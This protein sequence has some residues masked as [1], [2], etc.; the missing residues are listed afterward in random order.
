M[1]LLGL[2]NPRGDMFA[3]TASFG[4]QAVIRL[5]SSLILTRILRPEDYGI[6][7]M[8]MAVVFVVQMIADLATQNV[9]IRHERGEEPDFL[10]TAW[11]LQFCRSLVNAAA[12]FLLAGPISRIYA[13][14]ALEAPLRLFS[15]WFVITGSQSMSFA[16]A[17]REKRARIFVYSELIA[18][19]LSTVFSIVI[20][21]YSRN[22]WGMVY[23]ILLNQLVL[24]ALSHHFYRHAR[25]RFRIERSAFRELMNYS[26]FAMPS[27]FLTLC[28]NQFDKVIFL[29]LFDL[30][31]LGIYGLAGNISRPIETL[32]SRISTTVLYPRA[33]YNFRNH[34]EKFS[35]KYYR[36][37]VK[38]FVAILG[39]PAVIGGAGQ[40]II[41]TLYD[42]RYVEAGVILQACMLRA[43]LL[44][45]ASPAEDMLI[46]SGEYQ[47]IL[48]GS[49]YRVACVV[50]GCLA[51]YYF[52]G[53][54]GFAYGASAQVLA[55]LLYYF[56]LQRKKGYLVVRYEMYK[57]AFMVAAALLSFAASSLLMAVVPL[58]RFRS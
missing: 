13:A 46:A 51:G 19:L 18:T 52:F 15:L 26:R 37:N 2:I 1:K 22:Y 45:F 17:I 16:L 58:A 24:T 3:T 8:L 41:R 50:A 5:G 14:P 56:W 39:I 54:V 11:T 48:V 55:P 4:A 40:L 33:A 57:V 31:L 28:L 35:L 20:C 43:A 53:F 23:G 42:R 36:E 34:P 47:V 29:R 49:A 30:S 25:P 10:N 7:T 32:I 9:V 27:G 12:V 38:L 44:S 21:M 6:I